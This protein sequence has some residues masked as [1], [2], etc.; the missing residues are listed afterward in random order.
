LPPRPELVSRGHRFKTKP[1]LL[2]TKVAKIVEVND[3]DRLVSVVIVEIA[4]GPLLQTVVQGDASLGW[5]GE[6]TQ[7]EI[8]EITKRLTVLVPSIHFL[9]VLGTGQRAIQLMIFFARKTIETVRNSAKKSVQIFQQNRQL[10][11]FA[12]HF[13]AF[14]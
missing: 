4:G 7:N 10:F 14:L 2:F 6:G 11:T 1:L 12:V 8:Q 13:K 5:N 3:K 9:F